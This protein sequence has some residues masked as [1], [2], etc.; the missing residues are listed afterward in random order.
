[1]SQELSVDQR[2]MLLASPDDE[3]LSYFLEQVK[4]S[5]QLWSLSNEQGFVMVETDEGDCVMVWP[6]AE[7]AAQWAVDDWDDCEPVLIDLA[8]FKSTWLPSLITDEVSIAVFPNIEDEGKLL[9]ATELSEQ[10][11]K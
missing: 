10:L 1:M 2:V 5:S 9:T 7:F 6:D 11:G 4:S 3:R 8:T